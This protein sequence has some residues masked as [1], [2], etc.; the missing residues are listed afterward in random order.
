MEWGGLVP[1]VGSVCNQ[2]VT[3]QRRRCPLIVAGL[4]P[5]DPG[6]IALEINAGECK[7]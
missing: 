5:G 4:I 1:P 3:E 2:K 6:I 7:G